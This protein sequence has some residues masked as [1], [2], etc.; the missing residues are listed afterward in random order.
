MSS[1]L[2]ALDPMQIEFEEHSLRPTSLFD[3]IGQSNTKDSLAVF[4]AAAKSRNK[5]LDHTLFYGP[6]GLG[7][8]TLACIV[9]KELGVNLRT[10][11]GPIISK[12]G[13]LAALLTN[14]EKHDVLFIDEIHRLPS[15]V[16]EVLY[17]AM[18][19]FYID[20]ILGEGVSARS[21]K[22]DLQP[23][24]L[25]GATTRLDLLHSP[26]RDRF[27]IP[28]KLEFYSIEELFLVITRDARIFGTDISTDAAYKLA[29]CSRGTPRIAVRLLK[30]ARDFADVYSDGKIGINTIDVTFKS[31]GIDNIGLD[32][33][34]QMYMSYIMTY[35]SGG[36]VGIDT[37]AAG[38]RENRNTIEEAVEPYLMQIGFVA[39]TS[40]GRILTKQGCDYAL[41]IPA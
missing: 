12:T 2:G 39:R 8:T 16:E 23:F 4:I 15:N 30:R 3:F 28:I 17:S 22:I 13:D 9:A 38:L 33:L 26:L 24:T 7:K 10:T 34:A 19:D 11:S 18:E 40:K 36:P 25:V 14:L 1:T 6:P 41:A 31:M 27:G 21:I 5:P 32:R 29:S 37:I 20:I 35:Y